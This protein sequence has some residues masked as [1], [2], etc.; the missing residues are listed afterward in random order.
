LDEVLYATVQR[1]LRA[2]GR[3]LGLLGLAAAAMEP[4][5]GAGRA[6]SGARKVSRQ[7]IFQSM[8]P[9]QQPGDGDGQLLGRG[10]RR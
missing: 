5:R 1:R 6:V 9:A 3:L 4:L 8:A 7:Q 10:R 2:A